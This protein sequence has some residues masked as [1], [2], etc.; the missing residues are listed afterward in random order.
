MRTLCRNRYR[1]CP[2]R[3]MPQFCHEYSPKGS[4]LTPQPRGSQAPRSM[5]APQSALRQR[6]ELLGTVK[7]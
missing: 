7:R 6:G 5:G 1:H 2:D 3:C 4:K